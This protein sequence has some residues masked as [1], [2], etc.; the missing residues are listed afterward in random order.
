MP[1][2]LP[3]SLFLHGI[4]SAHPLALLLVRD[5]CT[6]NRCRIRWRSSLAVV[7]VA[8][9]QAIQPEPIP[10]LQTDRVEGVLPPCLAEGNGEQEVVG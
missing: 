2:A 6:L 8:G 3:H 7:V 1:Q 4:R 10:S 5:V 9:S